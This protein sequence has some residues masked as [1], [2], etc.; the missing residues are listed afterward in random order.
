MLYACCYIW[1]VVIS[2]N[3]VTSQLQDIKLLFKQEHFGNALVLVVIVPIE[4]VTTKSE[5][6]LNR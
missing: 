1:F 4:E 6:P 2:I 5:E 3:C